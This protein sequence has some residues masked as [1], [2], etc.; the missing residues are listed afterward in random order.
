MTVNSVFWNSRSLVV[1]KEYTG[2]SKSFLLKELKAYQ[3]RYILERKSANK[4]FAHARIAA[5][6]PISKKQK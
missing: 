6:G 2:S 5:V 1:F 4:N 3:Q